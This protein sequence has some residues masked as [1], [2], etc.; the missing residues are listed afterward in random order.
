[1]KM[2]RIL[3]VLAL[4]T[5]F[6]ACKKDDSQPKAT[7]TEM[8]A[9]GK[10]KLT[11][12]S[13]SPAY[14]VNGASVTDVFALYTACAKDNFQ[15]FAADGTYTYDEGATKCDPASAQTETGTWRFNSGETQLTLSLPSGADTWE[16]SGLTSSAMTSVYKLTENGVTYTFTGTLQKTN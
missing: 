14:P 8:L 11:A 16:I 5:A 13:V 6:S 3:T 12:L 4:F 2:I 1:M 10:W 9:G 15:T 7:K